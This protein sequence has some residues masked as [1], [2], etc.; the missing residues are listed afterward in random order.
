MTCYVCNQGGRILRSQ[1]T[2]AMYIMWSL[3]GFEIPKKRTKAWGARSRPHVAV[4]V[5]PGPRPPSRGRVARRAPVL[6]LPVYRIFGHSH[7]SRYKGVNWEALLPI[8]AA[9]ETAASLVAVIL[10]KR[11]D[12]S[13]STSPQSDDYRSTGGTLNES[14][15]LRLLSN[16]RH[17]TRE[18]LREV[19]SATQLF[20]RLKICGSL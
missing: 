3:Q 19:S 17:R 4:I 9:R 16:K 11:A 15:L 2:Y 20:R 8:T 10:C 6:S 12:A 14:S 18:D 13:H 1:E 7:A 5:S